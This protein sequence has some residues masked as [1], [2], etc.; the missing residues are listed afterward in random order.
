MTCGRFSCPIAHRVNKGKNIADDLR[1]AIREAERAGLT[2]YKL[3]QDCGVSEAQL[4]R[5]FRGLI[6]PKLSTAER[7]LAGIGKRLK[8]VDR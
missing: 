7:I 4:S 5:I 6:E 1:R 2:R 8:I 3:A